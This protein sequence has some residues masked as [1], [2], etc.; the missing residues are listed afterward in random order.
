MTTPKGISRAGQADLE[1]AIKTGIFPWSRLVQGTAGGELS[2][3]GWPK[4]CR[5]TALLRLST[6]VLAV[7]PPKK[8][9]ALTWQSR[10]CSMVSAGVNCT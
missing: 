1:N 3:A 9:K 2:S 6:M 7:A 5:S 8:L 4:V 10:K